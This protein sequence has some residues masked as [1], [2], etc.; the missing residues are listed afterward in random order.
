MAGLYTATRFGLGK[1]VTGEV[2]RLLGRPP[3]TMHRYI[4]DYAGAWERGSP[5]G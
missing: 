2:E 1:R 4:E 5:T 3:I